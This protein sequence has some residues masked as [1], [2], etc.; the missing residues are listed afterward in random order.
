[1]VARGEGRSTGM[2]NI[3]ADKREATGKNGFSDLKRVR[4]SGN[5]DVEPG[6]RRH[7][8]SLRILFT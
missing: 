6:R 3:P 2:K 1:M 7:K 8:K 5:R 4:A